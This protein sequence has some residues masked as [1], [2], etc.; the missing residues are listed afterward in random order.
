VLFISDLCRLI[1][2]QIAIVTPG[3]QVFNVG[4]GPENTL[5]LRECTALVRTQTAC[6]V[7]IAYEE[8]PRRADF[9]WYVS[10]TTKVQAAYPWAPRVTL[11]YGLAEIDAW[12]VEN[13]DLLAR[14]YGRNIAAPLIEMERPDLVEV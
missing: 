13:L 12:V 1:E 11:R 3:A 5:S 10:D 14:M 4:G 8:Q 2:M 9:K 6:K 7:P